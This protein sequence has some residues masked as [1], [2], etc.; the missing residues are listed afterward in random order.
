MADL[1]LPPNIAFEPPIGLLLIL[2]LQ[3]L[4]GVAPLTGLVRR[5][6]PSPGLDV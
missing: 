4:P 3:L 5:V 2:K 6:F 1:A